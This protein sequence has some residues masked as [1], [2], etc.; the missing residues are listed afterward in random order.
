MCRLAERESSF[1]PGQH[2]SSASRDRRDSTRLEID[3][4]PR[5]VSRKSSHGV[6][7][8]SSRRRHVS[9]LDG[10]RATRFDAPSMRSL[11]AIPPRVRLDY[12]LFVDRARRRARDRREQFV[13]TTSYPASRCSTSIIERQC[14]LNDAPTM[15]R[16]RCTPPSNR[17]RS[18]DTPRP[19]SRPCT[20]RSPSR[21]AIRRSRKR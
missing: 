19:R 9:A 21:S 1:S 8:A 16:E 4:T 10:V 20:R 11:F 15:R 2:T 18:S 6:A 5:C 3:P 7:S 14:Q 13:T 17:L 12:C